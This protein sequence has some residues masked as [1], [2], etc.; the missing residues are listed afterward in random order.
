MRAGGRLGHRAKPRSDLDWL[1]LAQHYGLPTRLLDWSLSPLAALYFAVSDEAGLADGCLWALS[2]T[3]LNAKMINTEWRGLISTDESVVREMI[4]QAFGANDDWFGLSRRPVHSW[5][6]PGDW[7]SP[8]LL[9]IAQG[10]PRRSLLPPLLAL[11]TA[12]T[13]ERMV[14]QSAAFT[15]HSSSDGVEGLEGSEAFLR[16]FIVPM[17]AKLAI[18]ETLRLLGVRRWT[19]FPDL[20]NLAAAQKKETF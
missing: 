14:A 18:R 19:L 16:Q 8:R 1:F 13:D 4:S 6:T 3:N 17:E 9:E 5:Q 7:Q 10:V 20:E 11:A 15:L 12:E 2:P